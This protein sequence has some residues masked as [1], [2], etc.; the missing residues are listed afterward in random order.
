MRLSRETR[1][2]I[3]VLTLCAAGFV[4]VNFF[5]GSAADTLATTVATT[6]LAQ[7]APL[8][9]EVRA[10]GTGGVTG[11]GTGGVTGGTVAEPVDEVAVTPETVALSL[12]STP[13]GAT[14]LLGGEPLEDVTP[15]V[16]T[17][18]EGAE[19]AR[20]RVE[21]DGYLPY[22]GP[23]NLTFDRNISVYLEPLPL[24]AASG[25]AG[26]GGAPLEDASSE[27]PFVDMADS[28]S[29]SSG[30]MVAREVII[31]ELPFL[32]TAPPQRVEEGGE[33][34]GEALAR[35]Q[36][37]QRASVNPFSPLVLR[38]ET[39]A[40]DVQDIVV[41]PVPD[42]PAPAE[43]GMVSAPPTPREVVRAPA[44]RPL[45]PPAPRTTRLPRALP[46]GSLSVT[47]RI[48]ETR[49]ANV[50]QPDLAAVAAIRVPTAPSAGANAPALVVTPTISP[51]AVSANASPEEGLEP[52]ALAKQNALGNGAPLFA[53]TNE[54]SR[55]LRD[56]DVTFTGTV[57]G[58]VGVGVFR[59]AD[60]PAPVVVALGETLPETDIVLSNL[61]G[62]QAEF[63]QGTLSQ[64]LD[65]R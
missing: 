39:P 55:Y 52:L 1:V 56:N 23:L 31:D 29:V 45:A 10:Q 53:G 25:G 9:S 48:L 15:F 64:T 26:S 37:E 32:I 21:L 51:V 54:L 36:G 3:G 60:L 65:R 14:V 16:E 63:I 6:A 18:V 28:E 30:T 27:G 49:R 42:G 20:L 50:P 12:S 61:S 8:L 62:T 40:Q 19:E 22:E 11:G 5:T 35:P 46:Q 57:P 13:E 38:I 47:P 34:E 44:P 59:F 24:E 4:W 2:T 41:V 43:E 58:P 7:E 17:P 33:D